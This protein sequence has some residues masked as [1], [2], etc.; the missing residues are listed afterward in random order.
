MKRRR[1]LATGSTALLSLYSGC[2]LFDQP[3]DSSPETQRSKTARERPSSEDLESKESEIDSKQTVESITSDFVSAK[4]IQDGSVVLVAPDSQWEL[5]RKATDAE[6][7]VS[8]SFGSYP[9]YDYYA[10]GTNEVSRFPHKNIE[11]VQID[12]D[13]YRFYGEV[14]PAAAQQYWYRR[15]DRRRAEAVG[16]DSLNDRESKVVSTA[17]EKGAES[18]S[19]A[20]IF[21]YPLNTKYRLNN[22]K[23]KLRDFTVEMRARYVSS[24]EWP[25]NDLY[26]EYKLVSD[27]KGR[28]GPEMRPAPYSD[29]ELGNI[30]QRQRGSAVPTDSNTY[31]LTLSSLW[32]IVF[33]QPSH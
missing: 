32:Q 5:L 3:T 8:S 26:A 21:S 20:V 11:N 16:I 13:G 22:L 10:L 12:G 31:I 30:L 6:G 29:E 28:A 7:P 24:P 4:E 14:T 25:P 23:V 9:S 18:L 27:K 1:W 2:V 33:S 15:V 19:K 17:V